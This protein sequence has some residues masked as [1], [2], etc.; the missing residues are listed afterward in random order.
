MKLRNRINIAAFSP[1]LI[2]AA[3]YRWFI[4]GTL[5]YG[6]WSYHFANASKEA[7][8]LPTLWKTANGLGGL[9]ITA[10]TWPFEFMGGIFGTLGFD[11]GISDKFI[12]MLPIALACPYGAY[13]LA[14]TLGLKVY[15]SFLAALLYTFNTYFLLLSTS[16]LTLLI[17]YSF[18]TF[19]LALYI[20][21]FRSHHL[22]YAIGCGVVST[23]VSIYEFRVFYIL[24]F[25]FFCYAIWQLFFTE[26]G[27]PIKRLLKVGRI[28]S[29][30]ILIVLL[31]NIYWLYALSKI[32]AVTSNALFDRGLFG[33]EYL[34][35]SNA[36]TLF[37]PFWTGAAPSAFLVQKIPLYNWLIP[38]MAILCIYLNR[39]RRQ[40]LFFASLLLVGFLLTK[41]QA[42]PFTGL[43]FWLYQHLPGFN[44]FREASKFF[45]LIALC[46]ALIISSGLEELWLKFRNSKIENFIT[47]GLIASV[48][49]I[50]LYNGSAIVTG[51]I[52][53]LYV[54]RHTPSDYLILKNYLE[55]QND[56]FRTIYLPSSSKW[57]VETNLHPQLSAI[58]SISKN[59]SQYDIYGNQ[60]S[61]LS[62]VQLNKQL[63]SSWSNQ[64]ANFT[65]SKYIIVPLRDSTNDNDFFINYGDNREYFTKVLDGLSWLKRINIGTKN[66]AVYENEAYKPYFNMTTKISSIDTFRNIDNDYKFQISAFNNKNLSFVSTKDSGISPKS[67]APVQKI[68]DISS[69]LSSQ[70]IRAGQLA[71]NKTLET[72]SVNML[73]ANTAQVSYSY[74]ISNRAISFVAD[75]ANDLQVN[76]VDIG[77]AL[78]T[79]IVASAPL[80][81]AS[82]YAL[83]Q[84]DGLYKIDQLETSS[85]TIGA[86]ND[87]LALY[88]TAAGTNLVKNGSFERG[89]WS[90]KAEDCN[91]YDDNANI[92]MKRAENPAIDGRYSLQLGAAKHTACTSSNAISVSSGQTYSLAYAYQI[93]GGQ[94]A[95]YDLVFNDAKHT[96]LSADQIKGSGRWYNLYSKFT[97]PA[98]A[99]SMNVRL[100]GYPDD[101]NKQYAKTFYD[102]VAVQPLTLVTPVA[103]AS[104][105]QYK[106]TTLTGSKL[107]A[108]IVNSNFTYKNL[109]VNPSLEAGLWQKKVG[110]CNAYDTN[111]LLSMGLD[112]NDKTDGKQSLELD[113]TRHVAC[114]GPA[115]VAVQEGKS[116]LLSFDYQSPD[117][118]QAGYYV[119]FDDANGTIMSERL[120]ITD[121]NWHSFTKTFVAPFGAKYMSLSVYSYADQYGGIKEI[122]RYDN[123][124]LINIPA[125]QNRYYV[126]STPAAKLVQPKKISF[127]LDSPTRKRVQITGAS[128]PFYLNMSESYHPQWRLELDDAKSNSGLAAWSPKAH[129]TAVPDADHFN[130]DDFLNSWYVDPA[131]LCAA[132][133]TACSRSADGSYNLKLVAEFAPQ[134]YFYVGLIVS[135]ATLVSCLSYLGYAF[136]KSKRKPK[137]TVYRDLM[138]TETR[139]V[140][141]RPVHKKREKVYKVDEP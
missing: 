57:G 30:S 130:Y 100:K 40:F 62:T 122:N 112:G 118:P 61:D 28:A 125:I 107:T 111:P 140:T 12:F 121:H 126:V 7:V 13:Y 4:S 42:A 81:A 131:K 120:P 60:D 52:K 85:R 129:P 11:S 1:L 132:K 138:L 9:N 106:A 69:P 65:S 67:T 101:Q 50:F 84:G 59:L 26:K 49:L 56:F 108:R 77:A 127:Q 134:R 98:G 63:T 79:N 15:T 123:F 51:R 114:T 89:L 136:V 90:S 117:A 124:S 34:N 97:V 96:V 113:A 3:F 135:G 93:K 72:N 74:Q 95:G 133:S 103:S 87:S 32:G 19:A 128:T 41:Q 10:G 21:S 66:L 53:T 58:D 83:A 64:Y 82:S 78:A 80:A 6:D 54:T 71:I 39:A 23:I 45:Y 38:F 27:S 116:Y 29:I 92:S 75:N 109:I 20:K 47:Y 35:L 104:T 36:L 88:S 76:G 46:Y 55:S 73:Y 91:K 8:G 86:T 137:Q 24:F 18:S 68:A 115:S 48:S 94:R 16:Q 22:R 99:T 43:Y 14:R 2:S 33:A 37:H 139:D 70:D 25:I 105:P 110:D 119:S 17:A 44:A 5:T 102:A 31:C 141:V